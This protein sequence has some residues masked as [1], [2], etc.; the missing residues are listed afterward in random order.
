ME[1]ILCD[2]KLPKEGYSVILYIDNGTVGKTR[3]VDSIVMANQLG[4]AWFS[5][6]MC[7]PI[8]GAYAWM[9]VPDPPLDIG[10][11]N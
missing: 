5:D 11:D 6:E 8:T 4:G 3:Y 1:W 10:K 7:V 9:D 2:E